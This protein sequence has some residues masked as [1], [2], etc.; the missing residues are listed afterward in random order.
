MRNG[1]W[2][3]IWNQLCPDERS[4]ICKRGMRE[5][6]CHCLLHAL[7]SFEVCASEDVHRS[8][9]GWPSAETFRKWSWHFIKKILD[10]KDDIIQMEC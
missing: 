4:A 7:L 9:V 5:P 1:I 2:N 10:L 3:P 6:Q 8:I